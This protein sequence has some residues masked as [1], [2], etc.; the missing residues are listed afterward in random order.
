[1]FY[2]HM[3]NYPH[4]FYLR[5]FLQKGANVLVWNYRGYGLTK[6]CNCLYHHLN[7]PSPDHLKE[8]AESVLGY[9]RDH[10]GVKGKIG[11]YGRSLGGIAAA[12]LSKY[13]DMVLI[14]RS[15]GSLHDVVET[16]FHGKIA[17]ALVKYAT[18]GWRA[19]ND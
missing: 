10:I 11:I 16:K 5:W 17:V 8:D 15:F 3:I 18:G 14:D 2:Q 12:H 4:A 13:V 7:V 1:M 9:L 6:P 19:S